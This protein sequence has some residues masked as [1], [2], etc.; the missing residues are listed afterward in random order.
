[1]ARSEHQKQK[2][3]LLADLLRR[4]T[5][6]EHGLTVSQLIEALARHGV[7]AERKSIYDDLQT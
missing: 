7:R 1:M 3:L 4:E 2:L 5:D 6:E